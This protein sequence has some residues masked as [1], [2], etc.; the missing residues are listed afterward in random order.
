MER[1]ITDERTGIDYELIGD[2]YIPC[3]KAPASPVIGK[4]GR[5]RQR[6]LKQNHR[7]QYM[8]LLTFG[9]AC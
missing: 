6:Y 2:Y 5:M 4:Y 7:I 3:L 9:Q 1:F 8:N